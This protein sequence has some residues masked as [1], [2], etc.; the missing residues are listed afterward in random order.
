MKISEPG[1]YDIPIDEYHGDICVGHSASHSSLDNIFNH[2]AAMY[3]DRCYANPDR[4]EVEPTEAMI[5]GR[6]AHHLFLGEAEFDKQFIL[7]P[8][9]APDGRAWNGNNL[10]CKE[11]INTQTEK[12]LTILIPEQVEKIRRMRDMLAKEPM[13]E[14]G[15]LS[16]QIEKSL[17]WQDHETGIWLKA[18]PDVIPTNSGD[19]SDLKVVSDINPSGLERIIARFGYHRQAALVLEGAHQVL[20]FPLQFRDPGEHGMSFTFVFVESKR[21]HCVE[22]VTLR[23]ADIERGMVENH[24]A[25]RYLRKC[26]DANDWPGPSG[27]QQDARYLGLTEWD[28]KRNEFR[29][30][31]LKRMIAVGTHTQDEPDNPF[32]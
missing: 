32:V 4:E 17:I 6:A 13:I 25:L 24:V 28:I 3:W 7:R 2:S 31:Q 23:A 15:L 19:F 21:P 9:E 27:H 11:W 29:V 1:I 5:L 12:G 22:L 18:R 14:L 8:D 20:G 16:G 10:S 30:D 26:L